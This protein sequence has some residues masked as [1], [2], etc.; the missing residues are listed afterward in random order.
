MKE[1]VYE[2]PV[3]RNFKDTDLGN[4]LVPRCSRCGTF[5]E[6]LHVHWFFSG[7]YCRWCVQGV[8][9]DDLRT[10]EDMNNDS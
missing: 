9:Y 2:R 10:L 1:I 4:V 7:A 8:L 3:W 5:R 6:P